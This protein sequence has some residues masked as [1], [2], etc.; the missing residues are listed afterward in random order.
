MEN[1]AM[2]PWVC[3]RQAVLQIG[4]GF[5]VA[6]RKWVNDML[7]LSDEALA[8]WK[9]QVMKQFDSIELAMFVKHFPGLGQLFKVEDFPTVLHQEYRYDWSTFQKFLQASS[10]SEFPLVFVVDDYHWV[11]LTSFRWIF[12]RMDVAGNE[13]SFFIISYDSD[14]EDKESPWYQELQGL[15]SKGFEVVEIHLQDLDEDA[16]A[17]IVGDVLEVPSESVQHIS[18][19][20][21][22]QTMGNPLYVEE[23]LHDLCARAILTPNG[24]RS[25]TFQ[26]DAAL[27]H[28]GGCTTV[29]EYLTKRLCEVPGRTLEV[30]K[31]AACLGLRFKTKLVSSALSSSAAPHLE[32]AEQAGVLTLHDLDKGSKSSSSEQS[33]GP[34]KTWQFVHNCMH[35]AMLRVVGGREEQEH[36]HMTVGRMLIINLG[37]TELKDD[38]LTV[39]GQV[40]KGASFI[41]DMEKTRIAQ[42]ALEAARKAVDLSSF[43]SAKTSISFALSLM[44]NRSWR[45]DYDLTLAIYDAAAEIAYASG[46]FEDVERMV[47]EVLQGGRSF[48]DKLQAN[49]TKM[50]ALGSL[51]RT[52]EAIALGLGL[53]NQ[54]GEKF[55][56]DPSP[57]RILY[58]FVKTRYLLNGKSDE[59]LLR[60]PTMTNTRAVSKMQI[61]NIVF[62]GAFVHKPMLAP[63]LAMR[64]VQLSVEHGLCAVSSVAFGVYG[65]LLVSKKM[66]V[67]EGTRMGDLSFKILDRFQA[68][69]W[70]PRVHAAYYGHIHGWTRPHRTAFEPLLR[71]YRVGLET[72]DIEVRT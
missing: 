56:A 4:P 43:E 17:S 8:K 31:V 18:R 20:V 15:P 6:L 63:L 14:K 38:L 24:D 12:D 60:L 35:E 27:D 65:M 64:M 19:W 9:Q 26:E 3:D 45:D 53:L 32:M 51:D 33:A 47:A 11:E 58:S 61:M 13:G 72:G 66:M 37:D 42:F 36:L 25:W 57:L 10:T 71:G 68:K 1:G 55:P 70:I 44:H 22:G 40:I 49:L 5:T 28:C 62:G 2:I 48:E 46:D 67:D 59:V 30:L 23:L 52:P 54:L 39:M 21:H 29:C 69:A 41:K 16:T 34:P 7:L 50:Y